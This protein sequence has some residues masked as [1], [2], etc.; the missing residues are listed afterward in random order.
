MAI[1]DLDW[2]ED[3]LVRFRV[4]AWQCLETSQ[5]Y[6]QC[7]IFK[8]GVTYPMATFKQK[9]SCSN[10]PEFYSFISNLNQIKANTTKNDMK[11]KQCTAKFL[12]IK[13]NGKPINTAILNKSVNLQ[14]R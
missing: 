11:I 6:Y 2:R 12:D 7:D 3:E 8:N 13:F 10:P 14:T 4:E 1:M 5:W 9:I